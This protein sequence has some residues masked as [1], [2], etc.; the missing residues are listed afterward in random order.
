M[1]GGW[2]VVGFVIS[3]VYIF[4][5]RIQRYSASTPSNRYAF[6]VAGL[7]AVA[8][9]LVDA[10]LGCGFHAGANLL[11]LVVLIGAT[12]TCGLHQRGE[13]RVGVHGHY[14]MLQFR[15]INRTLLLLS[16]MIM[17]FFLVWYLKKTY[18]ADF[19]ICRARQAATKAEWATA[20]S[21]YQKAHRFDSRNFEAMIGLADVSVVRAAINPG[22]ADQLYGQAIRWYEDVLNKYNPRAYELWVKLGRVHD[23]RGN[24]EEALKSYCQ[25]I[26]NDERNAAYHSALAHHY[27]HW[28]N[29]ELA[30][31]S[32]QRAAELDPVAYRHLVTETSTTAPSRDSGGL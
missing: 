4:L 31:K 17:A 26:Q 14:S 5:A 16:S 19:Y 18:P 15:G 22:E 7:A 28:G 9:A 30:Q 13:G 8:A 29:A 11:T 25:A 2:I 27:Q 6:T 20:E 23:A 12:L 32:F 3:A 10:G 21:L 1:L 24:R